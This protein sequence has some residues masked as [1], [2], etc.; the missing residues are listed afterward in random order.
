MNSEALEKITEK[1][2]ENYCKFSQECKDQNE[3]DDI[4]DECPMN[5]LTELLD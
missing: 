4:C 1:F 5:E 3:L 2:C